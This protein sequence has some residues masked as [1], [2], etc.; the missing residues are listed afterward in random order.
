MK[1]IIISLVLLATLLV[2]PSAF[3]GNGTIIVNG[4]VPVIVPPINY[5]GDAMPHAID[6]GGAFKYMVVPV[7]EEVAQQTMANIA[8]VEL[9][10]TF[11]STVWTAI[12]NM[13]NQ[14]GY[15]WISTGAFQT[16]GPSGW[17]TADETLLQTVGTD[18]SSAPSMGNA[19]GTW[20][21]YMKLPH[22]ATFGT[23]T[24]TIV[25]TDKQ[26]LYGTWS[27]QFPVNLWVSIQIPAIVSFSA[28]IGDVNHPAD[29][30][31]FIV[32][33]G[34]NAISKILLATTIPTSG[35]NTLTAD[36]LQVSDHADPNAAGAVTV[37][38]DSANAIPWLQ[39]LPIIQSTTTPAYWF[40]T[41]PSNQQTG[42]Y[43][44]VY[45]WSLLPQ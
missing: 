22:L 8:G 17:Q 19:L 14:L 16:L 28:T 41:I 18:L 6:A 3:A 32:T 34:S 21:F 45:T 4:F 9:R 35:A 26:G 42:T 36:H 30:M 38:L 11:G 44:F 2:I 1:R 33:Y 5:A 40:V 10:F 7:S 25:A 15:R 43:G 13:Q 24:M 23:W 37:H 31:P 39:N 29:G 20:M 27:T 12:E